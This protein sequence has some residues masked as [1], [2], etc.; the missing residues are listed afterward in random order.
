[1]SIVIRATELIGR[2]IVTLDTAEDIAEVKDVVFDPDEST[3]AGFA[4]RGRA[5]L[6]TPNAG[7]L[8]IA[9]VRAIGRDA[10]M[11]ASANEVMTEETAAEKSERPARQ[12]VL[13]AGVMTESGTSVGKVINLILHVQGAR[14][15][16]AGYE[17][18]APDGTRSLV[19]LDA[20]VSVSGETLMVADAVQKFVADDLTGFGAAI[21]Q[22]RL[23]GSRSGS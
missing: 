11:I 3:V 7:M 23:T 4:L 1:M 8:R 6:S 17:I 22:F 16:V 14:A 20:S 9:N 2:P 12:D 21:E 19:P 18:E 13:G 15:N 10:I 5:A